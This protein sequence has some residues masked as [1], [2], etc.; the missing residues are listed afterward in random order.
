MTPAATRRNSL[1]WLMQVVYTTFVL[2]QKNGLQNQAAA[3]AFYFLMSATP[4]L[5]LLS[6]AVRW[7]AHL[8]ETFAPATM[9]LAA[10]YAQ[11]H[12]DVLSS[13]GFIPQRAQ[14][15]AGSV[16]L[17]TLLLSSRGFVGAIQGAFKVIFADESKSRFLTRWAMPLI[18]IPVAFL[19]M[20]MAFLAQA[21][22]NFFANVDLIGA[23]QAW[24]LKALNLAFTL[25]IGWT[26]VFLAYWQLPKPKPPVRTAALV[27]I[28]CSL[29]LFV[30]FASFNHFF[31][32]NQYQSVY[33]ALGGV[34]FILIGA[35]FA[36]LL[37]FIGAQLLFAATKA[38]V[39]ALEKLC[40]RKNRRATSKV[41]S[42]VFTRS[43]RL[44]DKY[45]QTFAAGQV[46]I[47]EGERSE[48]SY[49]LYDG[50]VGVYK[51]SN[52]ERK[53]LGELTEGELFGEMAYLLSEPR[54]ATVIAETGVTAIVLPPKLL[55][56][57]MHY[58]AP[59]SR[60]IIDTLCQRLE[61]M[62]QATQNQTP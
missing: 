28:L 32:L 31:K 36:C 14:L 7:L 20:G 45:G 5:L 2:F 54:T 30:L 9:L 56:E 59:L 22:L 1:D 3:T 43:N 51:S 23:D 55:E 58:S 44:L 21:A 6:Y 19:L 60:R 24:M 49:L 26:L 53:K 10:L 33:G 25:L 41:E 8:A 50:R 29:S 27:G 15:G 18:I 11:L 13:T 16:G 46:L 39:A 40:I 62:N 57:L 34:V 42:Y 61:R 35:Y 47:H 48:T 12:F 38:D 52:G 37:F 4:L 17:V